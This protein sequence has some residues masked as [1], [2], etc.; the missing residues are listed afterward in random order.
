MG[1]LKSW[2]KITTLSMNSL[3]KPQRCDRTRNCIRY[4]KSCLFAFMV[5]TEKSKQISLNVPSCVLYVYVRNLQSKAGVVPQVFLTFLHQI[6][7][8][9]PATSCNIDFFSLQD[10]YTYSIYLTYLLIQLSVPLEKV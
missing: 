5:N 2:S 4:V 3:R 10:W 7:V 6:N 9:L 1:I 8:H